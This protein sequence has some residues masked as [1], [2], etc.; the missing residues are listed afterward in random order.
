MSTK[1]N[2]FIL[3]NKTNPEKAMSYLEQQVKNQ[4]V[5]E[6]GDI[7]QLA[8]LKILKQKCKEDPSQKPRLL[9]IVHD[10]QEKGTDSVKLEC[11]ITGTAISNSAATIKNSLNTYVSI[12]G[13]TNEINVNKIILDKLEIICKNSN[14]LEDD[15]TEDL[16]KGLT[17]PSTEIKVKIIDIV[18]TSLSSK[19]SELILKYLEK[20]TLT[21]AQEELVSKVL[22]LLE[23]ITYKFET[24]HPT[25]I[26]FIKQQILPLQKLNTESVLA[27]TNSLKLISRK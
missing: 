8:I 17:T 5:D 7:L 10:F 4:S 19:S 11:A 15:V 26:S 21:N 23:L 16:L 2:A 13:R 27:L 9:K 24:V 20:D 25:A 3:L 14:Y 1:R 12:L 6:I 18:M 22:S